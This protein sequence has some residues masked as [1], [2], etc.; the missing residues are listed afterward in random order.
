MSV[1]LDGTQFLTTLSPTALSYD[2]CKNKGLYLEID[3]TFAQY[4]GL[5][6]KDRSFTDVSNAGSGCWVRSY[7]IPHIGCC[8]ADTEY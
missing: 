6:I 3:S 8:A 1:N 7:C 4:L 2:R 5:T